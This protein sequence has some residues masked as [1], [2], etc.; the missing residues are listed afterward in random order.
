MSLMEHVPNHRPHQELILNAI[1]HG[2]ALI[3]ARYRIQY[4]NP[5]MPRMVDKVDSIEGLPCYQTF[6]DQ[7]NICSDCPATETFQTGQVAHV[8]R[9]YMPP[10]PLPCQKPANARYSKS[11]HFPLRKGTR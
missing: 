7:D 11:H 1:T 2:I 9:R 5:T 6:D 3:D 8:T 4:A 10:S